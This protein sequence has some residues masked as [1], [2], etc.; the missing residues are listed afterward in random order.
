MRSILTSTE[1]VLPAYRLPGL[2]RRPAT[3]VAA[4]AS[5]HLTDWDQ[6]VGRPKALSVVDALRLTLCRLRRNATYQDLHEDFGVGKTTI[7]AYHQ[8][9]VAFLSTCSTSAARR[10]WP[11]WSPAGS[12]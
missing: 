12:A 1:R 6:P 9:M 5:Q 4:L 8:Q 2:S 11:C 10:S 3:F 7:W